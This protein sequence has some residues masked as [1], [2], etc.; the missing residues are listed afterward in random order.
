M[1]NVWAQCFSHFSR[2]RSF[3]RREN[4]IGLT[5][6]RQEKSWKD[7]KRRFSIYCSWDLCSMDCLQLPFIRV[8]EAVWWTQRFLTRK[9]GPKIEVYLWETNLKANVFKNSTFQ[10]NRKKECYR[11]T[12]S[13]LEQPRS[14]ILSA[15]H[16]KNDT[17]DL[18]GY[19]LGE[20]TGNNKALLFFSGKKKA[21]QNFNGSIYAITLLFAKW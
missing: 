14:H 20:S 11:K 17:T 12:T 10:V 16:A 8:V 4:P 18:F 2:E 1:D 15:L 13:Y 21:I 7:S 6:L 19:K 3:K 5:F 9:F